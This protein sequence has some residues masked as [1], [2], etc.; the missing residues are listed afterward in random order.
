MGDQWEGGWL[1]VKH[2]YRVIA[3]FHLLSE[4]A[5]NLNVLHIESS[6]TDF[7]YSHISQPNAC[8]HDASAMIEPLHPRDSKAHSTPEDSNLSFSLQIKEALLAEEV[9]NWKLHVYNQEI[10]RKSLM[11]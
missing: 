3:C 10:F 1:K 9:F 8:K 7:Q 11:I 5:S 6:F 2:F 4:A